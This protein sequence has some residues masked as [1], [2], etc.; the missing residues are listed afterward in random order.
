[1]ETF[2]VCVCARARVCE[3]T[4][5]LLPSCGLFQTPFI[6]GDSSVSVS[7]SLCP[8]VLSQQ[9]LAALLFA[10]ARLLRVRVGVGPRPLL[11]DTRSSVLS[12][13]RSEMASPPWLL[14]LQAALAVL[15][16]ASPARGLSSSSRIC[17][18]APRWEIGGR[19]PMEE[20]LGRVVVV[21]LLK[22]S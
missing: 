15:L 6:R 2:C 18:A 11:A 13:R 16:W 7:L 4:V 12:R 10:S 9:Q 19:A 14:W 17:R 3:V 8:C 5:W 20:R 1:M 21:A 22:A